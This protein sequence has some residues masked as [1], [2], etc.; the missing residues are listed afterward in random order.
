MAETP[1]IELQNVTFAYN[2]APALEDATLSI[3]GR[4]SV[5]VVGPNGGG[6]TTLLKLVLGLLKPVHGSVRVFG[7]P[8]ERAR[9]RIGYLPQ[10][11]SFDPQFP[12]TVQD[13]VL[14]GRLGGARWGGRY[15]A[16]DQNAAGRALEEVG[17]SGFGARALTDLSGGQRQRVLIARA[18]ACDP[19]LLLLDEPT[20]NVDVAAEERLFETLAQLNSRM[21][22]VMVTHDLGFVARFFQR[23]VCVNR[24]LVAHPTSEITG[25]IIRDIYGGDLRMIRHDHI[26]S[27][28]GHRINA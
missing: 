26:C 19:H 4:E 2:G 11:S 21:A 16:A 25:E 3:G 15:S 5:C 24:R 22:I 12:V 9:A 13:V 7:L 17:L 6:K 18:L 20:A 23:V 14:M 10:Y 1:A 8:P 27:D 28:Q